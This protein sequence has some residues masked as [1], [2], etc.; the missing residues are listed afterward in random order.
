MRM[1]HKLCIEAHLT[2]LLHALGK[3]LRR[4]QPF[5]DLIAKDGKLQSDDLLSDLLQQ[6]R[7]VL[8]GRRGRQRGNRCC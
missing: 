8:L 3:H 2:E 6:R 1:A 4:E 5:S 7:I